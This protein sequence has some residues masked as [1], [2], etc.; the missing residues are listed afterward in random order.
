MARG[1]IRSPYRAALVLAVGLALLVAAVPASAAPAQSPTRQ[2]CPGTFQVLHNDKVGALSLPAGAYQLTVANPA[3]IPCAKAAQDLTEFLSDF[4]GKLRRPW[5][6]NAS[7]STFQ[8]GMD[9]RTSFSVARTGAAGGGPTPANPTA[10]A[11][12]G[13]FR[14]LHN[15]HIGTLALPK[16]AYRITLLNPK[17][18]SCAAATRQLTSFLQ[19]FNGKLSGFWKLDNATA[20]FTRG[21][22]TGTPAGFRIKPAVGP[23]PTPGSGGRYPAKGQPGEC[24]GTFRV[25]N[26]DRVDNL[27]FPAGPYLTF[28][29]KGGGASC[30]GLS[31][32]FR[33]FLGTSST[34]RGYS[35]NTA[36]GTFLRG[37]APVFRVKPASPRVA[38]TPR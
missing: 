19:D 30:S 27:V 6:V 7:Q 1:R 4:D 18:L 38:T 37:R 24:P 25:L 13:Y 21:G 33:R 29:I 32:L 17:A 15:D 11:C 3:A 31:Q 20:T 10:N 5:V 9:S 28:A 2:V 35:V 36:T 8:R 16:G 34:G 22:T 14:I 23:E 26:R 12:G